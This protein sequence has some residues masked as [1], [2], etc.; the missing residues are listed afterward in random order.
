MRIIGLLAVGFAVAISL[1]CATSDMANDP[2]LM[3]PNMTAELNLGDSAES[4]LSKYG[5]PIYKKGRIDAEG[6]KIEDWFYANAMLSFKDGALNAF[7]P[8]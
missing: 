3:E 6:N 5:K 7:K 1:G 4:I 8:K 2:K